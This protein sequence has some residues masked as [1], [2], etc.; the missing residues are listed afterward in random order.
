MH[1]SWLGLPLALLLSHLVYG[2]PVAPQQALHDIQRGQAD[3]N[4]LISGV[5]DS[6]LSA[7]QMAYATVQHK[8]D[9]LGM[10]LGQLTDSTCLSATPADSGESQTSKDSVIAALQSMQLSLSSLSLGISDKDQDASISAYGAAQQSL[11]STYDYLFKSTSNSVTAASSSVYAYIQAAQLSLNSLA[12]DVARSDFATARQD[13]GTV[14]SQLNSDV[15]P[16]VPCSPFGGKATSCILASMPASE[17]TYTDV[18]VCIQNVQMALNRL[19]Q[20]A[21]TGEPSTDDC[22]MAGGDLAATYGYIYQ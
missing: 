4:D 16:A 1:S 20:D 6:D 13:Y 2:I 14:Y 11:S 5:V 18:L 15:G 12:G 3:I 22:E 19:A 17:V 8:L 10:Y 21:L 9:N 7:A